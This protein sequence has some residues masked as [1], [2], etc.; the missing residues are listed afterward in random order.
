MEG[1]LA[2]Q[3]CICVARLCRAH[4]HARRWPAACHL[5]GQPTAC[6][7][8]TTIKMRL[9]RG[10]AL[11]NA[12]GIRALLSGPLE[13]HL[14][15]L[16]LWALHTKHH[17]KCANRLPVLPDLQV[18]EETEA[19]RFNTGI[20]AMME[21]VNGAYKWDTRPRAVLAP[22]VLLLAAYAPHLGE[23]MWQVG[24]LQSVAWT[25][26]RRVQPVPAAKLLGLQQSLPACCF[27][28]LAA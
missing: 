1:S 12:H 25:A 13:R 4:P 27:L 7:C 24:H 15:Y 5:R 26:Q 3:S 9:S 16:L 18:T 28:R 19:M 10:A 23:E 11:P 8:C 20:A 17:T 2:V 6:T 14:T 22:F 21:F